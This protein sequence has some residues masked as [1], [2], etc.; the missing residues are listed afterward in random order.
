MFGPLALLAAGRLDPSGPRG[1]GRPWLAG[2]VAVAVWFVPMA[3]AQPGGVSIWAAATRA[4]SN[5]ALL[6]TSVLDHATAG[7]DNIGTFAAYTDGGPRPSRRPRRHRRSRTGPAGR[8]PDAVH[9]TAAGQR[10]GR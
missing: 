3:L 8:H 9:Q 5:G 6:S 10:D 2:V 4:E 1:V 7:A